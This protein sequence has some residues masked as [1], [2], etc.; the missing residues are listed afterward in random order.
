MKNNRKFAK[1]KFKRW[2]AFQVDEIWFTDYFR[3]KTKGHDI[4]IKTKLYPPK[5]ELYNLTHQIN[6]L[7]HYI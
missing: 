6:W 4:V 2:N 1:K 7:F 3:K 5:N